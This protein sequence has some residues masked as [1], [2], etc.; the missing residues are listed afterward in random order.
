M[1]TCLFRVVHNL[2][3][4]PDRCLTPRPTHL[5]LSETTAHFTMTAKKESQ[6]PRSEKSI[7]PGTTEIDSADKARSAEVLVPARRVAVL[8]L[9]M[10]RSGTSALTRVINLLGADLSEELMP[11]VP[12]NNELGFWESM[13]VY[14][15]NNEILTSGG[16]AWDD[17]RSFNPSWIRSP[18]KAGFKLGAVEI[19]ERDFSRSSLFVLK[20]PRI[21]RLLPF[22]LEVLRKFDSDTRCVLP[23]RNPLEVAA[24]LT[25]RDGFSSPKS[26]MLWLRHMLDA[27]YESRGLNRAFVSY[28]ELLADWR[29]VIADLTNVVDIAWPRRSATAEV[30]I[31]RFLEHRYR[32]HAISDDLVFRHPEITAWVKETFSALQALCAKPESQDA[33]HRLDCVRHEFNQASDAFGSLLRSEELAHAEQ[34]AASAARISEL[35]QAVADNEHVAQQALEA[36]AL[37]ELRSQLLQRLDTI[38]TAVSWQ[39]AAP[40]RAAESRWPRFVRGI[41]AVPKFAWWTL[42]CRLP[43]RLRL[44]R[45]ANVLLEKRLFDRSWYIENNS[46]VVVNGLNPVL[47]WLVSGW[48]QGRDPNPLFD[49]DW[50]LEHNPDVAEAGLNPLVHYL[51]SGAAEG[52][53]PSERF[54]SAEHLKQYPHLAKMP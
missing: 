41:A 21:S 42:S 52:R 8:V 26:H 19:L 44:R 51:S 15:L 30:E 39:L 28:N 16:S 6:S 37:V 11:A 4:Y 10:H 14:R 22:W 35:Q 23:L 7:H 48:K 53:D 1:C 32:H 36:D 3:C 47:H 38:Q 2:S 24:S 27:E 40:V 50:Y 12:G 13:A 5:S 31:D 17:W 18:V 33:L 34:A 49:T 46:E 43:Q 9:G 29:S 25:K 54:N 45:M 20:D